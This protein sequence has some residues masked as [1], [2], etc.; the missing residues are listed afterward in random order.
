MRSKQRIFDRNGSI[1]FFKDINAQGWNIYSGAPQGFRTDAVSTER[2]RIRNSGSLVYDTAGYKSQVRD[3][4]D[5]SS[6]SHSALQHGMASFL[7]IAI[8]RAERLNDSGGLPMTSEDITQVLTTIIG[9]PMFQRAAGLYT[10]GDQSPTV[11]GER[12]Y[13]T[14]PSFNLGRGRT[15]KKGNMGPNSK[16]SQRGLRKGFM[17]KN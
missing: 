17:N 5:A 9:H 1:P 8:P 2:T 3:G 11:Q 4:T 13:P 16:T 12:F 10:N 15:I 6:L 14:R 7:K